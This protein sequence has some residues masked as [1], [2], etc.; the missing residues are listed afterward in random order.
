MMHF[1]NFAAA[2]DM[3]HRDM[4]AYATLVP[5]SFW[6]SVDV[7]TKPEMATFE[8]MNACFTVSMFGPATLEGC[9]EKFRADIKPNLPWADDHFAERVGGEP[10]N[11][12]VQWARWPYANSADKFRDNEGRFNHNYMERYWP[13][14]AGEW[15]YLE[16]NEEEQNI[17]IYHRLGD[18]NDV[19]DLLV[20]DPMTR[21]AY[22]PIFF[23]EDTGTHHRGRTP[24]TLG[25][26]L[27]RRNDKL[28]INYH[29]RSCDLLRHFRD[30][31]YLTARLCLW[32]IERLRERD[33]D[34][35]FHVL[36]GEFFMT[37][38]SLHLFKNDWMAVFKT[39]PVA[40]G[41]CNEYHI[42]ISPR[43]PA[44]GK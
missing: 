39:P 15:E 34:N 6:Q 24:C 22:I 2:I 1:P 4:E 12:G 37:I 19:I 5:P 40:K 11:P 18:L 30:D 43:S 10:I 25:Y 17:G 41:G 42:G 26:Q 32:F 14:W 38:A 31:I 28:H 20:R 23:P 7:S 9:L 21:Q 33:P 44:I 8:L 16:R 35:W 36:P 27:L 3:V 13:R 29:M